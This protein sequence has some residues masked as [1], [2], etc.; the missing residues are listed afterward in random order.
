MALGAQW[1]DILRL[2]I[3]Q[4]TALA[5]IGIAFGLG[6]AFALTRVM[7]ALLFEVE[8]GDPLTFV[9]V[10]L[11]LLAAALLACW[12]PARRAARVHPMAALRYE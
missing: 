12:L 1:S 6:G 10:S 7:R 4:G 3:R 8:P 9:T 11:L 5:I 2:V